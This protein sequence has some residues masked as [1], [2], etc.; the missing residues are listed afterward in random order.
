[1]RERSGQRHIICYAGSLRFGRSGWCRSGGKD[2]IE[3]LCDQCQHRQRVDDDGIERTAERFERAPAIIDEDADP[4]EIQCELN[5]NRTHDRR[6]QED[7]KPAPL[8]RPSSEGKGK[9]GADNPEPDAVE[10]RSQRILL[11]V[12]NHVH[13]TGV[14]QPQA[15][16]KHRH[17]HDVEDNSTEEIQRQ[18]YQCIDEECPTPADSPQASGQT[19]Q[20]QS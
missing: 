19:Y 1:M 17:V 6:K 15:H 14:G 3:R 20:Q 10:S 18:S 16:V 2:R 4:S 7:G 12:G 9:E 11:Q 8:A 13:R 5:R